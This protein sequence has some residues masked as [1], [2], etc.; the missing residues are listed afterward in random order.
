MILKEAPPS[1]PEEYDGGGLLV[2]DT[3]GAHN[4][5]LPAGQMFP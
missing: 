3:Y 4:V 5:K 1:A 2:E